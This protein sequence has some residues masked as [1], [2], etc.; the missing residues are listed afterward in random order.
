M[1]RFIIPLALLLLL[2][3]ALP[4]FAATDTGTTDEIAKLQQQIYELQHKLSQQYSE[5][6]PDGTN[7]TYGFGRGF[8]RGSEEDLAGDLDPVGEDHGV[9][10]QPQPNKNK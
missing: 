10:M 9:I 8:G 1:K 4:V 2:A 3:L 7:G 6:Y 5:E